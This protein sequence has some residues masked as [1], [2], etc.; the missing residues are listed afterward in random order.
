EQ[1]LDPPVFSLVERPGLDVVN[2][3]IFEH[4]L[5]RA[6]EKFEHLIRKKKRALEELHERIALLTSES[7]AR[8]V[9]GIEEAPAP[10]PVTEKVE[11]VDE[12]AEIGIRWA[13][14]VLRFD[15][16]ARGITSRLVMWGNDT[17]NGY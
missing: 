7:E 16:W 14:R 5:L 8:A 6:T 10:D 4:Y 11:Y 17:V 1:V 13:G 3:I 12:V 15:P 2:P 9:T